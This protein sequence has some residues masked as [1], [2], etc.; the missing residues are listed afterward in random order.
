MLVCVQTRSISGIPATVEMECMQG[1]AGRN[2]GLAVVYMKYK[3]VTVG[4]IESFLGLTGGDGPVSLYLGDTRKGVRAD[5]LLPKYT[6][7]IASLL[8]HHHHCIIESSS[9]NHH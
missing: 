5:H 4:I 8:N 2:L 3:L 6:T 7:Y 9:L 1:V